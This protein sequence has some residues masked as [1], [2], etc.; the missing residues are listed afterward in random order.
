MTNHEYEEQRNALIPRAIREADRLCG[1][2]PGD[3][4]EE[5][6]GRWNRTY[7]SAMNRLAYEAGL[8]STPPQPP[9][10]K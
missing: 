1:K 8:T 9:E 6:R 10:E 2:E 5:W 3:D 4:P 7:H